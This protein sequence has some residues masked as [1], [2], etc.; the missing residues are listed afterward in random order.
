MQYI[1]IAVLVSLFSIS[2][3][4]QIEALRIEKEIRS[5]LSVGDPESEIIAFME[6]KG[7][8]YRFDEYRQRYSAK[9]PGA[10]ERRRY[11]GMNIYFYVDEE[12]RFEEAEVVTMYTFI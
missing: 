3:C 7:W 8:E 11:W 9:E 12:M 2:G 5:E 1:K 10:A 4:G 6:E